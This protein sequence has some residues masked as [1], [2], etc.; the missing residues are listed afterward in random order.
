MDLEQRDS[1][2]VYPKL[3]NPI[4]EHELTELFTCTTEEIQWSKGIARA[5]PSMVALL[6]HLKVFQHIGR[7]VA[8]TELPAAGTARIAE[9]LGQSGTT[10]INHD[11]RTLYR[12]HRAVRDYLKITS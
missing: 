1:R 2:I 10:T 3:P 9:R 4:N 11:R 8:V 5:G 6:M 12:H 7:F